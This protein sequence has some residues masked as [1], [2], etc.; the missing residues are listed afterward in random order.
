MSVT[1]ST[2]SE[3]TSLPPA[4]NGFAELGVPASIVEV[5]AARNIT[6]PTPVQHET[7]P[8][9]ARVGDLV[10]QAKTGTGKTL[11]FGIPMVTALAA[12]AGTAPRALVVTPTREL[13]LQVAADLTQIGSPL[14]LRVVSLYGGQDFVPQIAALDAGV[15]IV[16]G[17]P[18]RLLDLVARRNLDPAAVDQ[19][20]LDEADEMLDMGFL[21]DV[22]RLFGHTKQRSRTLLFSA[23][24][25][26]TIRTLARSFLNQPTFTSVA[27]PD[28]AG[29]TV[30]GVTQYVY[31]VHGLD[32]Q[33]MLARLLQADGRGPTIVFCRTKMTAQ[34]LSDDMIERGFS[35]AALHGDLSQAAREKGLAAFREGRVDVLIATDVAARGIDVDGIT[36]VVN[37]QMPEDAATYLHRIGRTARAGR[38][39]IAVTFIEWDNMTQWR[40][41]AREIGLDEALTIPNET[42]STS[43]HFHTDLAIPAGTKGR[44][45]AA[46]TRTPRREH[47]HTGDRHTSSR[48]NGR[49][50]ARGGRGRPEGRAASADS[51][52]GDRPAVRRERKRTRRGAAC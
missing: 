26:P 5:L 31:K 23:T 34:R 1:T 39:G 50:D 41:M 2:T 16:V 29:N 27:D 37:Y 11:A 40:F 35:A 9:T 38:K 24:M 4:V 7:I 44:L 51:R 20:V 43:E 14:G 32:K 52:S 42:F 15:D 33:E 48:G 10:V 6:V 45:N 19:L 47:R 18:G 49:S 22:Q 8:L 30:A 12:P 28:G 36:H 17:T 21:P 13:C 46:P 3:P 25:P